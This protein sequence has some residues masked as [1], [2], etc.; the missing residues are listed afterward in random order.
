M[1]VGNASCVWLVTNTKRYVSLK[2]KPLDAIDAV[3]E[4]EPEPNQPID[5]PAL[6]KQTADQTSEQSADRVP[7]ANEANG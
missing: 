5:G 3:T 7:P 6:E 2:N 4:T 1:S